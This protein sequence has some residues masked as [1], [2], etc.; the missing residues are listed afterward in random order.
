MPY[1]MQVER[2]KIREFARATSSSND[3]YFGPAPVIPPTFLTTAGNFWATD[4]ERANTELG[5]ELARVL[6]GE[7][8]F[9]F[10]G[11]PPH[12]GQSL[13]VTH[14]VGERWEKEGK[15]GGTMRFAKLIAEYRDEDGALVAEQRTTVIET[16][17]APQGS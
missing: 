6:H 9:E 12:A 13:T 1:E 3:A 11:P 4:E 14:R 8:E 10:F 15:R 5:F 7:E 16:A 2:G 17:R